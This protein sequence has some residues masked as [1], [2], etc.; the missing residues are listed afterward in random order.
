ML[1]IFR[2]PKSGKP[3]GQMEGNRQQITRPSPSPQTSPPY[4]GDDRPSR[5][6]PLK[7]TPDGILHSMGSG[8]STTLIGK[9]LVFQGEIEGSGSVRVEGRFVGKLRISNEVII[10]EEGL[11]EGD[12][13]SKTVSVLGKLKGNV[14]AEDKI[15]IDVSG[16][17]IGDISAPRVVVAEGAVYKGKIDM[18]SKV[19]PVEV[20][21]REPETKKEKADQP[22]PKAGQPVDS[23]EPEEAS[24]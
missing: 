22:K 4:G 23:P 13:Q 5:N 12:I 10:G 16:S 2:T 11:V 9:G 15:T 6:I 17:M 7:Q 8:P 20:K 18:E 21:Q 14:S 3:E 24:G 19:K 1:A